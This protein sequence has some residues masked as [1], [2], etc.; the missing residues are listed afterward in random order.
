MKLAVAFVLASFAVGSLPA[1]SIGQLHTSAQIRGFLAGSKK[2][3]KVK[4]HRRVKHH[5]A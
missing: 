5:S 1:M 2:P 4:R 3:H